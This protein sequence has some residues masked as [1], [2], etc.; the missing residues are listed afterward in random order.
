MSHLGLILGKAGAIKAQMDA[1]TT[2]VNNADEDL[3]EALEAET[4]EG[5]ALT[6]AFNNLS[7]WVDATQLDAVSCVEDFQEAVIAYNQ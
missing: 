4:Q 2:S 7:Q 3:H 1:L 6:T 5:I